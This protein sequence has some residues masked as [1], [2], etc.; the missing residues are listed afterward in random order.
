MLT[1]LHL[2]LLNGF[3]IFTGVISMPLGHLTDLP[4]VLGLRGR[5]LAANARTDGEA[6]AAGLFIGRL[7]SGAFETRLDAADQQAQ[8][9]AAYY[10]LETQRSGVRVDWRNPYAA[11]PTGTRRFQP[12]A[13]PMPWTGVRDATHFGPMQPHSPSRF[14]RSQAHTKMRS[15]NSPPQGL[16]AINSR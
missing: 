5:A 9:G 13:P 1:H 4:A 14:T 12:P 6:P 15:T 3:L 7:V 10:A 2:L 11:P 8:R 16:S